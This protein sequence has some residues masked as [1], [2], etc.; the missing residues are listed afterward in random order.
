[1]SS[2]QSR[3]LQDA[4]T[5]GVVQEADHIGIALVRHELGRTWEKKGRGL[6][7][8]GWSQ[9]SDRTVVHLLWSFLKRLPLS[10]SS[11]MCFDHAHYMI[12]KQPY[13]MAS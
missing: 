9:M 4:I 1:M 13:K 12:A 8:D 3:Q 10:P 5:A 6:G 7:S 11:I 2:A